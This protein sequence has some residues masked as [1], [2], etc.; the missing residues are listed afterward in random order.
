MADPLTIMQIPAFS[1][2]CA[3]ADPAGSSCG[4]WW[5]IALCGFALVTSAVILAFIYVWAA[6]FRNN[7]LNSF[8]KMELYELVV[9]TLLIVFV[10]GIAGSL[11][12]ISIGKLVPSDMLPATVSPDDNIYM[13]SE[14]YFEEVG[15]DFDG[16]LNLNYILNM[17]VDSAASITP[18]SKPLGIGVV[19]S[20]LAGLASPLK[21][22]LYNATTALTIAYVINYAQYYSFIFAVEAFMMYYLPIGVFL[23][24]FMPTRRIG[25]TLMAICLSFLVV[26]PIL[27]SLSFFVFYNKSGPM[28]T[29]RQ[30]IVQYFDGNNFMEQLSKSLNPF[31]YHGFAGFLTGAVGGIGDMLQSIFGGIF[32]L[33]MV[34]PISIVGRVFVIGYIIPAFNILLFIQATLSLSKSFGE[35]IDI[36]SLTRMI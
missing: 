29:F 10:L 20:P 26:F 4:Y 19:S 22:L 7:E 33:A 25:G 30:F 1:T 24:S 8:V 5:A 9:T 36:S 27:T 35:E 32:V 2:A 15:R 31:S 21:Q 28:V 34:F 14:K 16:W 13:L 6:L 18:Y 3:M 17:Y 12:T 23:R 11:S